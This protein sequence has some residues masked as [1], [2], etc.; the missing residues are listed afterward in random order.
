MNDISWVKPGIGYFVFI[1]KKTYKKRDKVYN[2][3]H[4]QNENCI[5]KLHLVL[6]AAETQFCMKEQEIFVFMIVKHM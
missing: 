3:T 6:A 4:V 5:M 1:Q 2:F